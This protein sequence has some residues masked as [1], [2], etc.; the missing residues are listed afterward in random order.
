M[1]EV[2]LWWS[3]CARCKVRKIFQR[4]KGLHCP[5]STFKDSDQPKGYS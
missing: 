1:N 4:E 5:D 3:W 2:K